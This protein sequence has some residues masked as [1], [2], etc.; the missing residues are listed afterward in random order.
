MK[1]FLMIVAA[2]ALFAAE[3]VAQQRADALVLFRT[4]RYA[5]AIEVCEQEIK[6][7]P[8]NVD[9]YC[10]LCWSLV[11]NKQYAEGEQRS[12]EARK[13]A[14]NDVRLIEIQAEAKYYLGK[15][16]SAM[17]LFELY[18]ANA[19]SNHARI[20]NAYYYMGEIYVRQAKYQHAD[21]AF[22]SAVHIFPTSDLWW[23]R[24]GYAREMAGSYNTALTAYNK[25][26]ELKPTRD[27]AIR[28]KERVLAKITSGR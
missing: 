3:S 12:V 5:E 28:G 7:D 26:L 4:G 21:M 1:K 19:P 27:D 25:A 16:K 11:R 14:P 9:S 23:T 10:V 15:N 2:V 18:L 24:C 8:S 13:L 22:T 20:E 17:E 6:D